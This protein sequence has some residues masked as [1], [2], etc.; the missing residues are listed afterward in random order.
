[1]TS[2]VVLYIHDHTIVHYWQANAVLLYLSV[3]DLGFCRGYVKGG[4]SF[5]KVQWQS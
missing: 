4:S 2:V 3:V 1:M 5:C